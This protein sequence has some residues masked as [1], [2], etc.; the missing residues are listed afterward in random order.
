MSGPKQD[1][2]RALEAKYFDDRKHTLRPPPNFS[3]QW[4][5]KE[6]DSSNILVIHEPLRKNT[7]DFQFAVQI[8][9]F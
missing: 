8:E 9:I 2:H 5:T 6:L 3:S 1:V 4:A 7:H